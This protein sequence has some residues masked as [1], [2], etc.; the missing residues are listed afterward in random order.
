MF[1]YFLAIGMTE[2]QYWNGDPYLV[3]AF[4]KA[5]EYKIEMRNQEL[6]LQGLY[7]H[8]AFGVVLHNAFRGRGSKAEK[9]L[10]KPLDIMNRSAEKNEKKVAEEREKLIMALSAWKK[11]FDKAKGGKNGTGSRTSSS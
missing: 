5:H 6:W 4:K 8:N 3:R 10:E 9:Y 11:D 2:E 1:P 7:I